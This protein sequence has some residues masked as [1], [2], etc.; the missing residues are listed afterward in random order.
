MNGQG[1]GM[2]S[3][4]A[5]FTSYFAT[6]LTLFLLLRHRP[7]ASSSHT[8]FTTPQLTLLSLAALL[9]ALI[10]SWSRIYL[11][12]HSP[13]Q[14]LAGCIAGAI[15]AGLWFGVTE[16]ARR[17][18]WVE[19]GLEWEL[20]RA[21]R[22]RDLVVEEDLVVAGWERWEGKKRARRHMNGREREGGDEGRA[23]AKE[24]VR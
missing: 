10:V 1:Y 9:S 21:V 19:W 7:I 3:S 16:W 14:V 17:K 11:S 6:Y 23:D 12:Y 15:S 2:P 24:K 4:H 20:V 5:Q 22:V 13:I 18:G 8:P